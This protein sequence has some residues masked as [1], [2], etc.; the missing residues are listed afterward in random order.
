[1]LLVR[2]LLE[3]VGC[4]CG[5]GT[6][7]LNLSLRL[8]QCWFGFSIENSDPNKDDFGS[9]LI[10]FCTRAFKFFCLNATDDLSDRYSALTVYESL[11]YVFVSS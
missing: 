6:D 5:S 8:V 2:N 7:D 9:F 10:R 11:Q 1:M 4:D 3:Y